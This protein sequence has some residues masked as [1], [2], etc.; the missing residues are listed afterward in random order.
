MVS[1]DELKSLA[2]GYTDGFV[3]LDML[4]EELELNEIEIVLKY[5]STLSK[6]SDVDL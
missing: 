2:Q 4:E 6:S 5:A 1:N 3:T